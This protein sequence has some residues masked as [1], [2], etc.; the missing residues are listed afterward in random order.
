LIKTVQA[1]KLGTTTSG[2]ILAS[3]FA[4][5]GLAIS[6][7][8]TWIPFW[9]VKPG[10][11]APVTARL[12]SQYFRITMLRNE[13]HYL[14][15]TSSAC[16]NLVPRGEV[17]KPGSECAGLVT[18]YETKRR[19][20][21]A[22]HMVGLLAFYLFIGLTLVKLMMHRSMGRVRL[23]RAEVTVIVLLIL[24]MGMAKFVFLFTSFPA[25]VV[26][27]LVV[28]LLAGYFFERKVAFAI[29]VANSLITISLLN[30]DVEFFL[31]VTISGMAAVL[32]SVRP[33]RRYRALL[34]GGVLAGWVSLVAVVITT[35]IFSGTFSIYDD[36]DEH[37]DP[38][39]SLWI[40]AVVSGLASGIIATVLA[41]VMGR[42]IGEVSR[43]RL[44]DMQDLDQK[45]LKRIQERAPGT[46]EHSRAMANLAEAAVNAIGG[47]AT[48][49]RVGAY[50]HDVGKSILPEYF[51]E[52][53][54]G[55]ENPHDELS[56]DESAT[57]I[58]RH[59]TEGTRLLRQAG[60]P[61]D[62]VEFCYSHHGTSVLEYFW[63][64]VMAQGNP[65]EMTERHFSYPGHKPSTRE[66]GILMLVD[67]IEAGA[68]T[69]DI[70]DKDAFKSLVQ[71]IVF[72]KLSQGQLDESGLA[73]RDLRIV[74]NTLV[75][76][77]VNMYHARIKYPWQ[78][79][80]TGTTTT[81]SSAPPQP[82]ESE[83]ET[84]AEGETEEEQSD[85]EDPKAEEKALTLVQPAKSSDKDEKERL[86]RLAE[87]PVDLKN[88]KTTTAKAR[89]KFE[90]K[91]KAGPG[92]KFESKSR[93]GAARPAPAAKNETK[94]S[95]T[96]EPKKAAQS[97]ETPPRKT[98]ED[99]TGKV[100]ADKEDKES[101]EA[102]TPRPSWRM[103]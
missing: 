40:A 97:A 21:S 68:R 81:R 82:E 78:T 80:D 20:N 94:Q 92:A 25:L 98:R 53:Q 36:P 50:Y 64:K 2:L 62:V 57:C 83:E 69:V 38:R 84:R 34:K 33:Q 35:L 41:P 70:P 15:T 32:A 99:T 79:G 71:A 85:V 96:P 22:L 103:K 55:G 75:D 5:F 88:E 17:L 18:A 29:V 30:F 77:L 74:V 49:V 39:Y 26:P 3:I 31:I 65:E 95:T 19:T 66:T 86:R 48:L 43:A 14:S 12:P 93:A 1:R 102:S 59:V 13:V 87:E 54:G 90:S 16:P 37:L 4:L 72:S 51:I 47:N 23:L 100:S 67:A 42:I 58:F 91:L 73:L 76:T 9:E 24:A 56:P 63:H 61:E 7:L 44:L 52:N 89:A 46:W 10:K 6:T 8:D 60:V 27:V 11:A 45:L 28:P 101:A